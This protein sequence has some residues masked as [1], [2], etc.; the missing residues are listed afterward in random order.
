MKY[1]DRIY[2]SI[3]ITEPVIV[4]LIKSKP[5]QRLKGISQDGAPHYIQKVRTMNRFEHSVGAWYLSHRFERP[6]EEQIASLI[7][8]LPHTAFSHVIDFVMHDEK[9]EFH[10]KF[11]EKIVYESEIPAILVRYDVD[12][13]RVLAK[14]NF[15]LLE[16]DLPDISVDRWD[17]FTRDGAVFAIMPQSLINQFLKEIRTDGEQ[18]YFTDQGLAGTFAVMFMNFSRLFW[19]DPTSHGSFFL[20]ANSLKI[21][22][23]EGIITEEDFF[24]T[25]AEV[26]DKLKKSGNKEIGVYLDRLKPG[27]EFIYAVKSDAEFYGP[28]KPRYVDPLVKVGKKLKRISE[29]I[30]GVAYYFEEYSK[31]HKYLGVKQLQR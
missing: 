28:N 4:E 16:N 26:M 29:L 27:R 17:Y 21:A 8:D 5:M 13:N 30:P 22:L 6:I 10:E 25:D 1:N 15:P 12:I 11:M 19:L 9:H 2:G 23:K 7:H 18:F 3:D 31:T 14:D 20:I 24:T